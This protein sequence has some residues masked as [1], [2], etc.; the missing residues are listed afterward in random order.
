MITNVLA[1]IEA[2]D[3]QLR[4]A[5]CGLRLY[6]LDRVL[7]LVAQ[8]PRRRMELDTEVLVRARWSGF[9]VHYLPTRVVYPDSGRSH[10]R[11]L[12]DNLRLARMHALLLLLGAKHRLFGRPRPLAELEPERDGAFSDSR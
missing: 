8:I 3:Q 4:D 11:M 10:F 9:D 12:R 2:G 1:R 5:M 6:P 7:P